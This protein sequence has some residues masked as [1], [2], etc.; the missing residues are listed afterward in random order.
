MILI[1]ACNEAYLTPNT[2]QN[3]DN[4]RN[5]ALSLQSTLSREKSCD[6]YRLQINK[7][8][9][10][11]YRE[12]PIQQLETKIWQLKKSMCE[13]FRTNEAWKISYEN[14]L[15]FLKV[16]GCFKKKWTK[17]ICAEWTQQQWLFAKLFWKLLWV[18]THQDV[19]V[20]MRWKKRLYWTM[21]ETLKIKLIYTCFWIKQCYVYST[22]YKQT[23]T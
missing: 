21:L 18:W 8:S 7:I 23:R 5:F 22:V 20:N 2:L 10:C 4:A 13:V 17:Q 6:A 9:V 3:N 19:K 1:G 15:V 11:F 14:F 12:L 16:R